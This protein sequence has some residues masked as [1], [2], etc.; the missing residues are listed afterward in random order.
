MSPTPMAATTAKRQECI[1][2]AQKKYA[3][4]EEEQE[5]L[6]YRNAQLLEQQQQMIEDMEAAA[7]GAGK[8]RKPGKKMKKL[9]NTMKGQCF[10]SRRFP[11]HISM[12]PI[13]S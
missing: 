2:K 6:D 11:T 8:R 9:E 5:A 10:L 7:M 12:P 1:A 3:L 4:S 13:F